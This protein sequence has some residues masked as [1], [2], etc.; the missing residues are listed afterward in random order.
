MRQICTLLFSIQMHFRLHLN[1]SGENKILFFWV[2]LLL[3]TQHVYQYLRKQSISKLCLHTNEEKWDASILEEYLPQKIKGAKIQ[4]TNPTGLE[5]VN[6]KKAQLTTTNIDLI[7]TYLF[8]LNSLPLLGY[9]LYSAG[10]GFPSQNHF[11]LSTGENKKLPNSF[12]SRLVNNPMANLECHAIKKKK[13]G[14]NALTQIYSY[15]NLWR[16]SSL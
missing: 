4:N 12:T 9:Y 6:D 16:C 5:D 2:R 3:C 15:R 8:F 14:F 11:F 7:P 1:S 13:K 10:V